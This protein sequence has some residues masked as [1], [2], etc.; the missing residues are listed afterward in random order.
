MIKKPL[1]RNFDSSPDLIPNQVILKLNGLPGY[2]ISYAI[3]PWLYLYL[4]AEGIH[5]KWKGLASTQF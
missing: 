3:W 1:W 4:D 2:F 5:V